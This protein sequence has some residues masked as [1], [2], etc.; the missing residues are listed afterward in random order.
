MPWQDEA[1]PTLRI[2]INDIDTSSPTYSNSRLEQTLV[3]AARLIQQ[4]I[5]F[6]SAYTTSIENV[7]ISPD[8]VDEEDDAFLNMMVLKAACIVDQSTFRTKAAMEGVRANMGP[9]SLQVSGNL[10]GFRFLL[11]N[12]PCLTYTE[13]KEALLWGNTDIVKAVLSPFSGNKFDSR[14]LQQSLPPPSE[15]SWR[16]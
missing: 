8:P 12:G 2:L 5:D 15:R 4:D 6:S 10:S 1:I 3:V 16:S 14:F 11:E 9:T 13:M 7:T